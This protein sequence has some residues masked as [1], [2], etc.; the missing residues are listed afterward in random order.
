MKKLLLIICFFLIPAL[1]YP[2]NWYVDN[3]A[4]GTS[5]GTSWTNAWASFAAI[6]WASLSDGDTLYVSGGSASKTYNETM[7]IGKGGTAAKITVR[8]GVDAGH[9]GTVIIDGQLTREYGIV[10]EKSNVTIRGFKIVNT[11]SHGILIGWAA[12]NN[13][14]VLYNEVTGCVSFISA[15]IYT[16]SGNC[17]AVTI[18]H[19]NL[20]NNG[21]DGL[22]MCQ[23]DSAACTNAVVTNNTITDNN[24]D[25]V[26]GKFGGVFSNNIIAGHT[27]VTNHGDGIQY[28]GVNVGD[29]IIMS[30]NY[31][32]DNT[33]DIALTDYSD[34]AGS[35]P[36]G[37]VYIEN[38]IFTQS[39]SN[40]TYYNG[41]VGG[42]LYNNQDELYILNNTILHK[43]DGSGGI[44]LW[45]TDPYRLNKVYIK[46]NIFY[47]SYNFVAL[48]IYT[49]A[50][51][52]DYSL[53][54]KIAKSYDFAIGF[55]TLETFKADNPTLEQHS[56]S[57]DPLFKSS[58]DYTL[59]STSPAI[60]AGVN[61]SA[62]FTTDYS[63]APRPPGSAWTIGAYEYISEW[64]QADLDKDG[65][66]D[67]SDLALLIFN[68]SLIDLPTFA[69]EFGTVR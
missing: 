20:H 15:G 52:M 42:P 54:Y 49:T 12:V 8:N 26:K 4:T 33:Q 65:D 57:G 44:R 59:Q 30:G 47:D 66:V 24:V 69:R 11:N 45:K 62:I 19:N 41:V 55:K 29:Q 3:A 36:W 51:E 61:L 25:G 23:G 63:G 22:A 13:V 50:L 27:S 28:Q 31:I 21:G 67:G 39:E 5:A 18:D 35:R 17:D 7:I 58:T 6:T 14:D 60:A 68:P 37:K 16:Y 43:N 34:P 40:G 9:T 38:N 46:N 56:I 2:A 53:F 1:C 10:C 32:S 64:A 48:D